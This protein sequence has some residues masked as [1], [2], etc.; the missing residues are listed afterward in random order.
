MQDVFPQAAIVGGK[1]ILKPGIDLDIVLFGLV[2]DLAQ[3]VA[4]PCKAG[5]MLETLNVRAMMSLG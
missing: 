3:G 4:R 1:A 5:S 2:D